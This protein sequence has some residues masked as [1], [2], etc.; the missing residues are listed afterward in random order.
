LNLFAQWLRI[1]AISTGGNGNVT[2]ADVVWLARNIAGHTGFAIPNPRVANL[3]GANRPPHDSDISLLARW[4][5]GFDL[6]YL[7]EQTLP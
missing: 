4:L 1:G 6:N 2:S 7:I 5:V 3:R